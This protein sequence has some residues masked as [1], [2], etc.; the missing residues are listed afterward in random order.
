MK[1]IF[2]LVVLLGLGALGSTLMAGPLSSWQNQ[3]GSAQQQ[4]PQPDQTRSARSFVGKITKVAGKLVLKDSST[5]QAYALDD[6][7][8]AKQYERKDVQV[9]ATVDPDTN[10]LHVVDISRAERGKDK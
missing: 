5:Q 1:Q 3:A 6:Q 7:N 4:Q 8:A 2:S 10:T 9:I